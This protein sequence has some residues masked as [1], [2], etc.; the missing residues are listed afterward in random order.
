MRRASLI[1]ITCRKI[2]PRMQGEE[3]NRFGVSPVERLCCH[4]ACCNARCPIVIVR[5]GWPLRDGVI[6]CGARLRDL[7]WLAGRRILGL[8]KTDTA[9]F[10]RRRRG[11]V[12]CGR[13]NVS[14]RARYRLLGV[15]EL[16]RRFMS[17]NKHFTEK[18]LFFVG[19]FVLIRRI[20]L[21]LGGSSC[22]T[23]DG[24]TD[25]TFRRPR[26]RAMGH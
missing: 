9:T 15:V 16:L 13:A 22:S 10:R 4:E 12:R 11:H 25:T 2:M 19:R 23:R 24:T 3:S 1:T 17:R 26:F 8:T 20:R 18:L 6:L 21:I 14:L 7:H 5:W